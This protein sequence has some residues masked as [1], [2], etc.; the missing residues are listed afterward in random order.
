MTEYVNISDWMSLFVRWLSRQENRHRSEH[1]FWSDKWK[2]WCWRMVKVCVRCTRW[3]SYS[4]WCYGG[5]FPY[6]VHDNDVLLQA[7]MKMKRFSLT[8]NSSNGYMNDHV[9][10]R[11]F[12]LC[13]VYV[14]QV[15][16]P[17]Q[18][19]WNILTSILKLRITDQ[20]RIL[21]I[22]LQYCP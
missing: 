1:L 19:K 12:M 9:W 7:Y 6:S 11:C 10:R 17:R 14:Y 16:P 4:R 22:Y 3:C 18:K 15:S 8:L 2:L 13:T 21:G 5:R 20:K